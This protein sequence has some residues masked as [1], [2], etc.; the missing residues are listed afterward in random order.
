MLLQPGPSMP[1]SHG[2]LSPAVLSLPS[3]RTDHEYLHPAPKPLKL[4][5]LKPQ[6]LNRLTTIIL[7]TVT[8]S[9]ASCLIR[10]RAFISSPRGILRTQTSGCFLQI[11][12][13]LLLK[14]YVDAV[15]SC[16]KIP[17][18]PLQLSDS[19]TASILVLSARTVVRLPLLPAG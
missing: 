9:Q 16:P 6:T 18:L 7:H 1:S 12:W 2:L 4:L 5:V 14:A 15:P 8:E 3:S 11:A 10:P 19:D 17:S 13:S